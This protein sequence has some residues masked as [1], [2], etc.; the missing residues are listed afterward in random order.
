MSSL[1]AKVVERRNIIPFILLTSLFFL[2]GIANDLTNPMVSAFKKVM[3]ELSNMEAALVQL[4]FYGGYATMAIPASLFI[5][6]Y[7]Y[8]SGILVGLTLYAAGAFLFIPA[9]KFEV[10]GFF[11]ASLYIL[12]FGLAFLE[13]TSNPYVLSMGVAATATRRLNLAQTFNPLG[14]L[15]GIFGAQ[16]LVLKALRSDDFSTDAYSALPVAEQA[17]VKTNDLAIISTP[18]VILGFIVLTI[19]VL[20]AIVKMPDKTDKDKQTIGQTYKLLFS[21]QRYYE[22]VVAQM[23]YVGAQIMCWT[24]IYQY[25]DNLNESRFP[26]NQLTATWYNMAAMVAFF[27]GRSAGTFLLKYIKPAMLMLVFAIGGIGFTLSAIFIQGLAGLISLV[28]IS[29]T[30]SIMF[31][32]IYGLALKGMGDE[33]K[34][35]SAGLVMAIVG[36]ALLPPLQGL[37]LDIGG[38]GFSDVLLLG[39][40]EVN[41][42]YILPLICLCVVAIYSYRA[43]YVYK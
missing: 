40:P 26:D 23:F 42:S 2:W 15:L 38:P 14:S 1:T 9:A 12:T 19:L 28:G 17:A 16:I 7:S 31:P 27:V 22:G 36:G 11:L 41:F 37:I 25:V 43:A 13:T 5:R 18:Y 32:T 3:P 39:V 24:F 33:A 34:L 35:A 8:K 4:A 29:I 6:K 20:I 21:N 30:M 10:F